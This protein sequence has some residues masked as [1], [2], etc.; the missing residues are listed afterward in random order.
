M[1]K[2]GDILL[3]DDF[4]MV[5]KD[6]DIS[7]G[8][9]Q[10]QHIASIVYSEKGNFRKHPTLGAGM[11]LEIDGVADSRRLSNKVSSSLNADGWQLKELNINT[12]NGTTDITVVDAVKTTDNTK[13]LL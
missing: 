8:D 6:G 1:I 2:H 10:T 7:T 3:N 13:S 12:D 4:E 11:S 9:A 5:T